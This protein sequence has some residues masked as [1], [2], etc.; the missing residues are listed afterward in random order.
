MIPP[1]RK[2]NES[3]KKIEE[4]ITALENEIKSFDRIKIASTFI[5][6]GY[7]NDLNECK[8]VFMVCSYNQNTLN[9]PYK[10]NTQYSN[11]G[12]VWTLCNSTGVDYQFLWAFQLAFPNNSN[13]V[14]IRNNINQ[15]ETWTAWKEL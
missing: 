2:T 12:I 11:L 14:L 3:N 10:Q 13:K 9:S 4:R 8:E 15:A 7:V 5:K 1:D 6:T